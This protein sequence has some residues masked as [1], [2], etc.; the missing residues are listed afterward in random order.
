MYTPLFSA[1]SILTYSSHHYT[2]PSDAI[3]VYAIYTKGYSGYNIVIVVTSFFVY[4]IMYT[5]DTYSVVTMYSIYQL[6]CHSYR[7]NRL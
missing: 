7:T 2:P 6:Y 3:D 5:E 1:K 4:I